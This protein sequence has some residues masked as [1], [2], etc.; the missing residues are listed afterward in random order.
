MQ[1][2][3]YCT[4]IFLKYPKIDLKQNRNYS[5]YKLRRGSNKK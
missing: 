2:H 3:F 5:S 4:T 1:I